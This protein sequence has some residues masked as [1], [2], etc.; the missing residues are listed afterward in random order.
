MSNVIDLFNKKESNLD[1]RTLNPAIVKEYKEVLLLVEEHR[2][3]LGKEDW[4]HAYGMALNFNYL[5]LKYI[6]QKENEV[7]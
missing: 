5:L 1:Q 4:V 6:E 7:E 2:D 3:K